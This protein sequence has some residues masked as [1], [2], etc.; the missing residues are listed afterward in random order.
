MVGLF[1]KGKGSSRAGLFIYGGVMQYIEL[2]PARGK[3]VSY[4][5]E[6]CVELPYDRGDDGGEIF[7][8][9]NITESNLKT[10]KKKIGRKWA[11]NVCAG[12]QSKDVL[13]RTCELGN[14]SLDD[15]RA[16]FRYEFDKFFP[17]PVNEAVY[18]LAFIE[19][20][21]A[22]GGGDFSKTVSCIASAVRGSLVEN[23]M[24][25]AQS[26]GINLSAI[27]PAP[28]SMLRCLM[29]PGV[30][31]EFN[32]YAL[33]GVVSSIIVAAYKDNGIVYRNTSQSFAAED[34]TG[35]TIDAFT[36]DMQA[37]IT[38]AAT[39]IRDFT[40]GRVYI[41]GYG[42]HQGA[43][44]QNHIASVMPTPVEIVDPWESWGITGA[45]EERFGWEVAIGLA[46]RPERGTAANAGAV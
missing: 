35:R 13:I 21:R 28:V 45:P 22:E 41:G 38:F 46:M 43:A 5:V 17:I 23:L 9:Y 44:I 2:A 33:A 39:Q 7:T 20:P 15:L 6:Q 36:R 14:M 16:S 34:S 19:R 3:D 40:P 25:A 32:I 24:T 37:T 27:E 30:T 29:G 42:A 18:D 1:S 10:L 12:I 8:N 31:S 11:A 4:R 26:V